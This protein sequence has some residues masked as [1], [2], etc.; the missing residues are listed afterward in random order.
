MGRKHEMNRPGWIVTVGNRSDTCGAS[1]FHSGGPNFKLGTGSYQSPV[2]LFLKDYIHPSLQRRLPGE[3]LPKWVKI[4][5]LPS[6][7]SECIGISLSGFR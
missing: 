5:C 7:V 1:N 6:L 3:A 4:T 2:S